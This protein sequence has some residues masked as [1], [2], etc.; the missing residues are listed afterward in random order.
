[1]QW[2]VRLRHRPGFISSIQGKTLNWPASCTHIDKGQ[3]SPLYILLNFNDSTGTTTCNDHAWRRSWPSLDHHDSIRPQPRV[4]THS[5]I[6]F[7]CVLV[8]VS[9]PCQPDDSFYLPV[10]LRVIGQIQWNSNSEVEIY[11]SNSEVEIYHSSLDR[12]WNEGSKFEQQGWNH[13]SLD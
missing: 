8:Y 10:A 4:L 3:G 1:M 9:G 2:E 6:S 12:N 11:H 5:C 7:A 13:S